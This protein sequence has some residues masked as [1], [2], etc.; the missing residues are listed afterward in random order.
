M[1]RRRRNNRPATKTSDKNKTAAAQETTSDRSSHARIRVILLGAA[2]VAAIVLIVYWAFHNREREIREAAAPK[3]APIIAANYVGTAECKACHEATYEAWKGSHHALAMQHANVQSVLGNF[4]DAKFIYSGITSTFF[5]RNSKFF[6]NTD[7]PDGKLRDYEIKYTFGVTPLQQYLIEMPGARFQAL[8]IAWD[9][10]PKEQGGQRWFHLYPK[11]RITHDD[12]LHWTRPSQNWNFMCADCHSTELRK[13]YDPVTDRF[14]TE[15]TEIS[16]GCEACHGPGSRHLDWAATQSPLLEKGGKGG[17]ES[18]PQIPLNPPFPKGEKVNRADTTK[19]LTASLDERRGV[20]WKPNETTGN[21]TRSKVRA[22][23]REIEVCAQCHARRGQ[24]AEGYAPGRPFLDYYR[25][26]FLTSPLYHGDGQQRD[27]VYIW[28]SF[29][30]SK[31]YASGV[32]C[33]DCHNPHSGKLRAEGSAVCAT[34]HLPSK[35]DAPAH[36]HHKAGSAGAACVACHMPTTT[37]MVVDP[38]HDHSLRVPRPDL[39][40]K[41]GTPNPCNGCHKDRDARWAAAQVRQWYGREPRGYQS[42]A[43]AFTAANA[44]AIDAS[45][46]LRAIAADA[47]HPAIARA[48]ALA[49]FNAPLSKATLDTLS[50]GLRDPSALVRLAALQSLATSSPDARVRLTAPL[51]A[52][53]MKAIRIEAVNVLAPVPATQLSAEQRAAFE[54]A[55][56]EYVASQRY[57][58]DRAEA[59]VNLGTFYA[60]RAEPARAEE[61]MKTAIRLDPLFA[62]A[63]VNLADLYRAVG[64]DADGEKILREGIRVAPNSAILHHGLGLALVRLKR[65]DVALGELER[66]TMLE[67]G[68]VR[69]AYV[70]AVALHSSGKVDAALKRL[71]KTLA[72]DPNDRDVLQALASFHQARGENAAA[73]KY[74]ERLRTLAEK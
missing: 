2:A 51:L 56:A 73:E 63:Y 18:R 31:M 34:C 6:V 1:A 54:R 37:Y 44:G 35:Y 20:T 67:P 36:H 72:A 28:G 38:R 33:S 14:K 65:A 8:S 70:Y 29:L 45:A 52:D 27:E 30:Q 25:P 4:N 47:S 41:L 43:G 42:F 23:E 55:S 5:K 74:A 60:N 59:R 32:T 53:P 13:N 3:A 10:R 24:I 11:E 57:N 9:S 17:F 46:Q 21:A 58:A 61:E 50:A 64:R 16:V 19:G 7:G 69:F 71:E 48:T 12:E 22:S 40:M 49:Q 39:S 68:N 26:A 66:A 15:W 62:P